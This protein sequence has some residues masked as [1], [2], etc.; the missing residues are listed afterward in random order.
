M[1]MLFFM[2]LF[3]SLS[4]LCVLRTKATRTYHVTLENGRTYGRNAITDFGTNISDA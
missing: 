1:I 2:N 4:Y 3:I